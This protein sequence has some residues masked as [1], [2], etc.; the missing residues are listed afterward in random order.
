MLNCNLMVVSSAVK[1]ELD[2]Q[3]QA[4]VP[5][6]VIFVHVSTILLKLSMAVVQVIT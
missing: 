3:V 4:S 2:Q 5:F 6:A 1:L